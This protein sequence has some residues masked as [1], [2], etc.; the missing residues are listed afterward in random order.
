VRVPGR[1]HEATRDDS[2]ATLKHPKVLARSLGGVGR[3]AR[4]SLVLGICP[5]PTHR[6]PLQR[7]ASEGAYGSTDELKVAGCFLPAI[8]EDLVLDFLSLVQ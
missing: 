3:I 2:D 8:G 4:G 6:Y 7:P 5:S 1:A